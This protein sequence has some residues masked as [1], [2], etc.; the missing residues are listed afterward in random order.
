MAGLYK[1]LTPS[2]RQ[3]ILDSIDSQLRELDTCEQNAFVA[4]ARVELSAYEIIFKALPDGYP[5]L[6]ERNGIYDRRRSNE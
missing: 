1:T 4:A 5:V 6:I 3:Q 2:F